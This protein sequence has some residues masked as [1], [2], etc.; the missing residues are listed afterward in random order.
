MGVA[1][2]P[3][4]TFEAGARYL[5][6]PVAQ[7]ARLAKAEIRVDG[8]V[9]RAFD[10][11][12][13]GS[14]PDFW[15]GADLAAFQ[16]RQVAFLVDDEGLAGASVVQA[17]AIPGSEDLYRERYRP[18]FHF[19]AARGWLNDPN[20]LVAYGGSY[21]L[22]FQH[23][24]YANHGSGRN[25]HWGLA[26][27]RDLVHWRE[28]GDALYPDALGACW[29]GSAVVDWGNSSGL[30]DGDTPPLV[31]AYTSAGEPFTQSLAYSADGG[32]T[33]QPYDGNPVVG[34]LRAENRDPKL[35]WHA[36]TER[37][38]MALYLDGNAYAL[39]RSRD[40]RQ[41]EVIQE[42]TLAG[43]AECPDLFPLALEGDAEDVRWV[44]WGANGTYLVGEFDGERFTPAQA[45]ARLAANGDAYAAQTWSDI[46]SEDGR[47]IQI[48]WLRGD[49]PGMPFTQQMTFPHTLELRAAARG[50]RL[51]A[52]P[53]A[54]IASLYVSTE[55][56][57]G[58]VVQAGQDPLDGVGG[59]LLDVRAQVAVGDGPGFGLMVRGV[60]VVYDAGE[61]LLWCYGRA[62][63]CRPRDGLVDLR[64]LADRASV[65][66]YGEG[67]LA[68][69]PLRVLT[70]P[71]GRALRA[72]PWGG[73]L[74]FRSLE[75]HT[76]R[77]IW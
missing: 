26:T 35:I 23:D 60:P 18:Q 43:A 47:R 39:L 37:W 7:E 38:I 42:L 69:L 72:L 41:W 5:C 45:P 19:S 29:S 30:G 50:M 25:K 1:M 77:S 63:R 15:V 34:H 48:A 31:C 76:L 54:E 9:E 70:E 22:F 64:I 56:W 74:V 33:W 55:R 52:E 10:I 36:P 51:A 46:P 4:T 57:E 49:L 68:A 73:E 58:L 61:E 65:E 59:E 17:D 40:L 6:L 21:Y 14:E 71:G 12:L 75:V 27:S 44:F 8:R 2:H 3:V 24:P 32:A 16:G 62:C 28:V 53:V 20:G 67:G 11:P 13:T 66:L